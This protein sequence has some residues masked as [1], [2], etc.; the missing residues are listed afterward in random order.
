MW[1]VNVYLSFLFLCIYHAPSIFV[2][3]S[4]QRRRGSVAWRWR[5][6]LYVWGGTL[7]VCSPRDNLLLPLLLSSQLYAVT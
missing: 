7:S 6:E 2:L 5:G 4:A 1:K 3:G